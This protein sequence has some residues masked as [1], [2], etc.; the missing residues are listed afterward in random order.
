LLAA[1]RP[2][3]VDL[4]RLVG[5]SAR[6]ETP[7]Y[8]PRRQ[9]RRWHPDLAI[10]FDYSEPLW[11]YRHDMQRLKAWL[12][13]E[14]G[15]HAL[16]L[17]TC[18]DGPPASDWP[19]PKAGAKLLIVG[20]LGQLSPPHGPA[21]WREFI[22]RLKHA[23]VEALALVPLGAGQLDPELAAEVAQL[24]W[25]PDAV[26]RPQ[27]PAERFEPA[28]LDVL[29]AQCAAVRRVDPA[30]LR[31]LR[32]TNPVAPLDAGLEGALWCHPDVAAG[33]AADLNGPA[34][35]RHRERFQSLPAEL[36]E[37][38]NR[39]RALHH[40]H[41][42]RMVHHEETL[43]LAAHGGMALRAEL[44]P[45][46]AAAVDFFGAMVRTLEAW[47]ESDWRPVV[48]GL[49]GRVDSAITAIE[50]LAP[51]LQDLAAACYRSGDAV[52]DWAEVGRLAARDGR[53]ATYW[54]LEDAPSRHLWLSPKAPGMRQSPYGEPLT[55]SRVV[56][57][58]EGE[59]RGLLLAPHGR[60]ALLAPLDR[61][62]VLHLDTPT[63]SLTLGFIRRP[64]GVRSWG[65]DGQGLVV[66]LAPLAGHR[67]RFSSADLTIHTADLA[68]PD[69]RAHLLARPVTVWR[70]GRQ[71]LSFG[72]DAPHGAYADLEVKGVIQRF[73]WMAAGEFW[74]GSKESEPERWDDEGP[75]HRVRISRGFWL[76][77]TACSQALW[78]AVMGKNP[79]QFK[80]DPQNPVEQ[81]SW[82]D[83][84]KFFQNM[85]ALV[86]GLAAGFPSEAQWEYACRAGTVS[87]FS[88]GENITPEQVN[89]DGNNPYAGGEKGLYRAKTVP[90]ASLPANP[91]GL[92]EMHGNVWE[93]CSDWFGSYSAAPSTDPEGPPQG[94]GRVLRGGS[95]FG[96]GR[97][98]RSAFRRHDVPADRGG[99]IGLRVAPG[100][101]GP[102]EPAV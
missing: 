47:P 56:L 13:G 23:G 58:W 102:A 92:H 30:L 57:R 90:V 61:M 49:L 95:W 79:A 22:G 63:E 29:L 50:G 37:E 25:S 97:D 52:P 39:L 27:A 41:L 15:R 64:L 20:D 35:D 1:G 12:E 9:T 3:V 42:R 32:R 70:Q 26:L 84:R 16:A 18:R 36:Q 2:G 17:Q 91:W 85:N 34:G 81:V 8:L 14:C 31:A 75:R 28:G 62:G 71:S 88:F 43:L 60:P 89:Y 10:L 6:L 4:P 11:P 77:D 76:A 72:L 78:L 99:V 74:M 19:L 93:W 101:A 65:R 45:E 54:L 38:T 33:G 96:G 82:N 98:V 73:R 51:V 100:R 59:R 5:A 40:E 44:E 86:P 69:R 67:A 53:E 55:I 24:R 66:E 83:C 46:I 80:D 21:E 68:D 94:K 87:P 48:A 7:R